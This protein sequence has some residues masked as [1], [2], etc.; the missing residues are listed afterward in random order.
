MSKESNNDA[1]DIL[2]ELES[3]IVTLNPPKEEEEPVVEELEEGEELLEGEEPADGEAPS[4][5]DQSLENKDD[6]KKGDKQGT[7]NDG[8]D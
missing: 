1:I 3:T 5:Q 6:S 8:S 7:A 4:D 2:S